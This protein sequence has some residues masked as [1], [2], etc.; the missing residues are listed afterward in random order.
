MHED[1]AIDAAIA[2][3]QAS[4]VGPALTHLQGVVTQV[5]TPLLA[6]AEAQFGTPAPQG[7]DF[8]PLTKTAMQARASTSDGATGLSR[9]KA[10]S[11]RAS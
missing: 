2:Y 6:A 1:S 8:F 3:I 5:T 4:P 10:R 11:C 9:T 7:R